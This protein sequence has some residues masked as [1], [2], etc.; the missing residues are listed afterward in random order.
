MSPVRNTTLSRPS[1]AIMRIRRRRSAAYP[2]H[3]SE[4]YGIPSCGR[5][6]SSAIAP[7]VCGSSGGISTGVNITE[8][9]TRFQFALD[10]LHRECR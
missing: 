8:L 4:L 1:S 6:I 7:E 5:P 2:S 3:W 10:V 9:P